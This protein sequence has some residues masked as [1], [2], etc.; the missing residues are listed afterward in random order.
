M[1]QSGEPVQTFTKTVNEC[2][3][4][5]DVGRVTTVNYDEIVISTYSGK[6][7]SFTVSDELR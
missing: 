7:M 1:D 6:I 4:G 2:V 5:A 3:Q